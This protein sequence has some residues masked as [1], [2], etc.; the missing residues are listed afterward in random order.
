MKVVLISEGLQGVI[1]SKSKV[2][3]QSDSTLRT[4]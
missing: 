4:S 1:Y 2:R 3:K